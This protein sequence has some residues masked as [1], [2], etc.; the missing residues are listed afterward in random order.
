VLRSALETHCSHE[1]FGYTLETH[2]SPLSIYRRESFTKVG[3]R[4][5][6]G[7]RPSKREREREGGM[8]DQARNNIKITMLIQALKFIGQEQFFGGVLI[9]PRDDPPPIFGRFGVLF[10]G[11]SQFLI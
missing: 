10:E 3:E 8:L 7:A 5:N 1:C 2:C 4:E 6:D 11:W 9:V